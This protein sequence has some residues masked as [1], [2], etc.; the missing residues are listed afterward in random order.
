MKT[1][2]SFITICIFVCLIMAGCTIKI[3][4]NAIMKNP[5]LYK[6][7]VNES[8]K[9]IIYS[10]LW[11]YC[12]YKKWPGNK[13]DLEEFLSEGNADINLSRYA[14]IEIVQR[15]DG[16]VICT[17]MIKGQKRKL[18]VNIKFKD[19]KDDNFDC[20]QFPVHKSS[21]GVYRI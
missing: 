14:T 8:S 10:T 2:P 17:Y 12:T 6:K 16:N 4:R 19:F 1:K 18:S 5:A 15:K 9:P 21:G 3:T 20:S 11:Y 13:E 7:I